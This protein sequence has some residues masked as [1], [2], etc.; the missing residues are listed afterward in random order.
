[1][2]SAKMSGLFR[3]FDGPGLPAWLFWRCRFRRETISRRRWGVDEK[4]AL[5][6][7]LVPL[8]VDDCLGL[9]HQFLERFELPVDA[10][11]ADIRHLVEPAEFI[12]HELPDRRRRHLPIERQLDLIFYFVGH[13]QEFAVFDGPFVA[14]PLQA[15]DD[16]ALVPRLALAAFLND[17]EFDRVFDAL[18]CG[19]FLAA[20]FALA[21]P[22]DRPPRVTI[23]RVDYPELVGLAEGAAHSLINVAIVMKEGKS[24]R[25]MSAFDRRHDLAFKNVATRAALPR[26]L[27]ASK[28]FRG[29]NLVTPL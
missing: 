28:I 9:V 4:P 21:P 26:S 23:A 29:W 15:G 11:K 12:D 13:A 1:L 24:C 2:D 3:R 19:E 20:G 17:D 25:E 6:G 14:R 27:N 5:A 10:G 8:G 22:A 18:V 16:L 7:V